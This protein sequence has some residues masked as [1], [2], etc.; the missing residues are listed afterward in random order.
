MQLARVIGTVV[1]TIKFPALTGAKLLMIQPLTV[2][3]K[4]AGGPVVA[5][6]TAQA[7]V[8]DLV[9]WVASREAALAW[10]DSFVPIDAAITGIVDDVNIEDVKIEDE[11]FE[12]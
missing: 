11:V 12:N 9:Y 6:D 1:A 7:G 10:P 5:V 4:K 3:L 8:N 2:E